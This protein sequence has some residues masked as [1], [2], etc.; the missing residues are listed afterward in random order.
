M[1]L[2][3]AFP[4][5]TGASGEIIVVV[6]S[7]D[8]RLNMDSISFL[9]AQHP[10][11]LV[12]PSDF[13]TEKYLPFI[14]IL[15]GNRSPEGTGEIVGPILSSGEIPLIEEEGAVLVKMNVWTYNQ[16][17]II[18]AGSHR[19]QTKSLCGSRVQS[20]LPLMKGMDSIRS[21]Y[22][23]DGKALAFLWPFLVTPADHISPYLTSRDE[24]SRSYELTEPCWFF[25]IDEY[26]CAKFAHPCQF[27]FVGIH[28]DSITIHHEVWWPV[29]NGESVWTSSEYW[30]STYWVTI[31]PFS[32]PI[33]SLLQLVPSSR[34]VGT[35]RALIVNGWAPGHPLEEDLSEDD[36]RMRI[37]L[38][39]AGLNVESLTTL[40]AMETTCTQWSADM[41]P[42]STFLLYITAHGSQGSVLLGETLVPLEYFNNLL[43][44]FGGIHVI[45]IID[46][47]CG[48]IFIEELK[49]MAEVIIMASTSLQVYGDWDPDHDVNPTDGGSEFS[50]SL[51]E[52]ILHILADGEWMERIM[53]CA[54]T[55][56]ESYYTLLIAEAFVEAQ[57]SDAGAFMN[58]T[59]PRIWRREEDGEFIEKEYKEESDG[60]A[61]GH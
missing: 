25:W 1:L 11:K 36:H 16:A 55:S 43:M 28:T 61:C 33:S 27:I 52:S 40:E 20:I 23:G 12:H 15:G 46:A 50:S 4:P 57:G 21:G 47:P 60:C 13:D 18:V 32:R 39:A 31:P 42:G 48:G 49:S 35:D 29:L 45:M 7:I 38:T 3:M 34:S 37:I 26:S 30:N 44:G 22:D 58:Y 51:E 5:G 19:E 6:N 59:L 24:H 14:I 56:R 17:V 10:V 53:K 8:E 54:G 41:A 2:G 9:Q